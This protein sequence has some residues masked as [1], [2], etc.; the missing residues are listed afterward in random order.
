MSI[1]NSEKIK[2]MGKS[3]I[4]NVKIYIAEDLIFTSGLGLRTEL[5]LFGK[6]SCWVTGERGKPWGQG[7]LGK[8]NQR[9]T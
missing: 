2:Y 3:P 9:D 5:S 1:L 4:R 7:E 6:I 8:R